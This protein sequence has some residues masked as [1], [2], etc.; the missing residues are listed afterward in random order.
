MGG[1]E[2][3]TFLPALSNTT[4][5]I[6]QTAPP[7][8]SANTVHA[9]HTRRV[10]I[11]TVIQPVLEQLKRRI[12]TGQKVLCVCVHVRDYSRHSVN[13][14]VMSLSLSPLFLLLP[15]SPFSPWF[16]LSL[17]LRF[18]AWVEAA[19]SLRIALQLCLCVSERS[20][21]R[22]GRQNPIYTH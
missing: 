13:L 6:T 16:C 5:H 2:S 3:S 21:E 19:N 15:P 17:F 18:C 22:E 12:R 8:R 1:T 9:T 20:S 11:K 7:N 10:L 4:Q 14:L